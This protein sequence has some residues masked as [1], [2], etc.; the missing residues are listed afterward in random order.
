MTDNRTN[1]Q[2]VLRVLHP[3]ATRNLPMAEGYAEKAVEALR[4]A[5]RL[6]GQPSSTVGE[7]KLA[8][9]IADHNEVYLPMTGDSGCK[10]GWRT[11]IGDYDH[12]LHQARAVI[13]AIG[14]EG[15]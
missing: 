8:E 11:S 2:I 13:E 1:E 7:E 10:C 14:G 4:A 12:A 5:G 9:V 6:A 3:E 15:R